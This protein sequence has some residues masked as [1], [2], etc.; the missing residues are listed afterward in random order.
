MQDGNLKGLYLHLQLLQ[1][2]S[3]CIRTGSYVRRK[4]KCQLKTTSNRSSIVYYLSSYQLL[5]SI[6]QLS[7]LRQAGK[8][9]SFFYIPVVKQ[10]TGNL[11][12]VES[13]SSMSV[14][15]CKILTDPVHMCT[16][17]QSSFPDGM[18]DY[19]QSWYRLALPFAS[20]PELKRAEC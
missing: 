2:V 12:R 18:L 4:D 9:Y 15:A 3:N 14:W 7:V 5:S 19:N 13:D 20:F 6:S 11:K 10:E 1:F 8:F 17:L 16:A